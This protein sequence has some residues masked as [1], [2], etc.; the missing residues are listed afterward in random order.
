MIA[1]LAFVVDV[2]A[3]LALGIG[4]HERA[5]GFNPRFR[6]ELR[7]LLRPHL[8]PCRVERLLQGDQVLRLEPAAEIAGRGGI[9]RTLGPQQVQIGFVLPPQFEVFQ[10]SAAAQC[11]VGQVEHVIRFVIGQMHLEQMQLTI[12]LLGQPQVAHHLMDQADPAA[13]GADDAVRHFILRRA[14]PDHGACEVLGVVVFV[15]TSQQSALARR[16]EFTD[17]RFHSNSFQRFVV[18]WCVNTH[19][20]PQTPKRFESFYAPMINE[21]KSTLD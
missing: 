16:H 6:E 14:A 17:N 18:L 1:P 21:P 3:L 11:V 7:R 20:T 5:I 13:A 12:D 15:E 10:A 19:E 8:K 9:G 2:D 4:S